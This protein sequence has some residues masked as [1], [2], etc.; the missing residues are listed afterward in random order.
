MY[1]ETNNPQ[2]TLVE[3]RKKY[4]QADLLENVKK[5]LDLVEEEIKLLPNQDPSRIFIGG[6]S[7]GCGM[8]MAAYHLYKGSSPI[9]GFFGLCGLQV[10]DIF[11]HKQ[12]A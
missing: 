12:T 2:K 11:K 6:F 9:G 10:L 5:I 8:T 1:D 3:I 7:Q 4:S